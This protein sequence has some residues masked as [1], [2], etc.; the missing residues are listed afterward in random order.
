MEAQRLIRKWQLTLRSRW[1]VSHPT[2]GEDLHEDSSAHQIMMNLRDLA[3]ESG[4][5]GLAKEYRPDGPH[6]WV[7]D[8]P[9]DESEPA[10]EAQRVNE[11]FYRD[12]SR[13]PEVWRSVLD[14]TAEVLRGRTTP[15]VARG[16][17]DELHKRFRTLTP[18]E[19]AI[20]QVARQPKARRLPLGTGVPFT[21][22]ASILLFNDGETRI[23][24][25]P[26]DA[27]SRMQARFEKPAAHPIFI[28]GT[29]PRTEYR[30]GDSQAEGPAAGQAQD[31]GHHDV[32]DEAK[33]MD[34][35]YTEISFPG[36]N[37]AACPRW[38]QNRIRR[39]RCN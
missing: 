22:L 8:C 5:D 27:L 3:A 12:V 6:K 1:L 25:D 28:F 7:P 11:V 21:H 19:I 32:H 14:L 23:E 31:E 20:M 9:D 33:P 34:Y 15:N 36:I 13:D 29:A 39:M 2:L 30:P 38:V 35:T 24:S 37:D 16:P 4:D 10:G 17:G 18:C 26:T